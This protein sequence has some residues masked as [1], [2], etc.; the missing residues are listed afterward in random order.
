[1][2]NWKLE[3]ITSSSKSNSKLHKKK[4][5]GGVIFHV[6]CKQTNTYSE[7]CVSKVNSG[8]FYLT[9]CKT[10]CNTSLVLQ[11]GPLIEV[12]EVPS[13]TK[14]KK[15]ELDSSVTDLILKD[16]KNSQADRDIW[17]RRGWHRT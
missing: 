7:F 4:K 11:L 10:K 2:E 3:N 15:Y 9:C 16:T 6:L 5:T 14:N 1:M 12:N 8:R 13:N 17:D